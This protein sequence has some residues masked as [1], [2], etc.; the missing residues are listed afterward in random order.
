MSNVDLAA[1]VLDAADAVPGIVVDGRSLLTAPAT[2]NV[3]IE[4]GPR[5]DG[6][7]WYAAVRSPRFLYFEHSTGEKELYDHQVDPHQLRSRHADP[8]YQA[9]M[10]T[11][12]MSFIDCGPAPEHP[13]DP[14]P[15]GPRGPAG[16][17]LHWP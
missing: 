8:A 2:R 17:Y 1:T 5:P 15:A 6:S 13:A 14:A 10:A 11:S 9:T 12:P 16:N 3:L 4:T 7:R